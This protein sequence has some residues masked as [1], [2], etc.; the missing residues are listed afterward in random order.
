MQELHTW[1]K[2]FPGSITVCDAEGII[3]AMNDEALEAFADDGGEKLIG[4]NALDCHPEPARTRL[5]HLLDNRE[6]NVYTIEKHG[7]RKL[8]YQTP[9]YRDGEFAG[10]IELSLKI[11]ADMPHFNRD[12]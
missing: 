10:L 12:D 5:R 3:L 1:V 6:S 2:E 4:T 8:I 7:V 9:W 11:P